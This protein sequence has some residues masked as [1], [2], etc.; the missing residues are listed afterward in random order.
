MSAPVQIPFAV[1]YAIGSRQTTLP[2][3]HGPKRPCLRLAKRI[4]KGEQQFVR[5]ELVFSRCRTCRESV[6]GFPTGV[7]G[8]C[9]RFGNRTSWLRYWFKR[10]ANFALFYRRGGG[11]R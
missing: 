9:G 2:V 10:T 7:G 6:D 11:G 8:R 5:L 1:F 3:V 4:K